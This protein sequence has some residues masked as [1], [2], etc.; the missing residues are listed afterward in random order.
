MA[1]MD[2]ITLQNVSFTVSESG[3]QRVLREKVKN[4]HAHVHGFIK[5]E[6]AIEMGDEGYP[7]RYNPYQYSQ[8]QRVS[9]DG[10]VPINNS[11][12]VTLGQ[13]SSKTPR[14]EAML[15]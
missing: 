7:L 14:M 11:P 13:T 15:A 8:F 4:V 1:H 12:F 6:V 9:G 10:L 5:F 2:G 3:R